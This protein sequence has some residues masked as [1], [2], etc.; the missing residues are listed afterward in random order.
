MERVIDPKNKPSITEAS[1]MYNRMIRATGQPSFQRLGQAK[2][3]T[4]RGDVRRAFTPSDGLSD[5]GGSGESLNSMGSM[6][7][8]LSDAH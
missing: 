7:E 3:I 2:L 5:A 8:G 1:R 4:G 6:K